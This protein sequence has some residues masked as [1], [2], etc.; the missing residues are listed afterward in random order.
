MQTVSVIIPVKNGA[1]TLQKCLESIISQTVQAIEIIILDS[2]S[3]DSSVSIAMSY[4]AK[5]ITIKSDEFSHGGTRNKGALLAKGDLIYFTVQ[6]AALSG[7]SMLAQMSL[8]FKDNKT[9][10]VTGIQ[11]VP[12]EID[13]NPARW[14]RRF[15]PPGIE[16][17]EFKATVFKSLSPQEQYNFSSW[18]NV[19]SMY[20]REALLAV[21]FQTVNY[22]EDWLWAK[23]ALNAGFRI[24]RDSSILTYHYHHMSYRYIFKEKFIISYQMYFHFKKMPV[25]PSFI[26]DVIKRLYHIVKSQDLSVRQKI[27]WSWHNTTQFLGYFNSILVFRLALMFGGETGIEKRYKK[28]CKIVPQGQLRK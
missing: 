5:V 12:H 2:E 17:R 20:R 6:D 9:M 11:G 24:V 4:G 8:H 28:I 15:S 19:N 1:E 14:F 7:N 13:K 25:F 18:D 22:A 16:V 26:E 23:D 3:T 21:P 10:G 27:Y